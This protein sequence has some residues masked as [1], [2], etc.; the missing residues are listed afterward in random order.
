M[1]IC[2]ILSA[3]C[4]GGCGSQHPAGNR[5]II[6]VPING[7]VNG[8]FAGTLTAAHSMVRREDSFLWMGYD[9]PT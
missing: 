5:S 1:L 3:C 9:G 6:V 7:L 4:S 8:L 2:R